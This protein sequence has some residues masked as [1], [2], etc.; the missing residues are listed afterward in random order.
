M[1]TERDQPSQRDLLTPAEWRVVEQVREGRADA[2]IAVRLGVSVDAVR[3]RVFAILGKLE[4]SD[5]DALRDWHPRPSGRFGGPRRLLFAAI[6]GV[7]ALGALLLFAP[8]AGSDGEPAPAASEASTP[9]ASP[10]VSA[11]APLPAASAQPAGPPPVALS[12]LPLPFEQHEDYREYTPEQL[13]AAGFVDTGA[14]IRV[15]SISGGSD[16]PPVAR[17]SY[18][19]GFT[20]LRIDAAGSIAAQSGVWRLGLRT[21]DGWDRRRAAGLTATIGGVQLHAVFSAEWGRIGPV[22]A[23]ELMSFSNQELAFFSLDGQQPELILAVRSSPSDQIPA[24]V[25]VLGHLW[26][27]LNPL[28]DGPTAEDTGE[29]LDIGDAVALGPLA[30]AS[31]RWASSTW[32][33]GGPCIAIVHQRDGA[34]LAAVAAGRATCETGDEALTIK[35]STMAATVR[36]E[37]RH[38]DA[39]ALSSCANDFP[40]DVATGE[41][42]SPHGSW[43]ISAFAPDGTQLGVAADR[44]RMLYIDVHPTIIACPPCYTGS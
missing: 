9:R 27:R 18:R 37:G 29:R 6:T 25:D 26:V 28:P 4:L 40:R 15:A 3:A 17:A 20:A 10:T 31:E 39:D 11:T 30:A 32:C 12:P 13:A 19:A 44:G 41:L 22:A 8:T 14:F 21:D 2:E 1:A 34:G 23:T 35:L 7:V 16:P 33:E 36:F 38:P 43:R 24:V 5:R 42:L